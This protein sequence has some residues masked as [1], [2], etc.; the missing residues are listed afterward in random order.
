MASL[1][2]STDIDEDVP[3]YKAGPSHHHCRKRSMSTFLF[4]VKLSSIRLA[5]TCMA[6][7]TFVG[8][9]TLPY[10]PTVPTPALTTIFTLPPH[11]ASRYHQEGQYGGTTDFTPPSTYALQDPSDPQWYDCVPPEWKQDACPFLQFSPGVCPKDY[12]TAGIGI[13]SYGSRTQT[14]A[15]CCSRYVRDRAGTPFCILLVVNRI[16]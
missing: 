2:C 5:I 10:K 9:H 4:R 14:S 3:E 12:V 6:T 7:R 15:F 8:C 13:T 16:M 11:C 1:L